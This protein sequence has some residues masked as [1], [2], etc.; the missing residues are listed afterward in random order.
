MT[1]NPILNELYDVRS[2]ILTEHGDDL[3]GYLRS[4]FQRLRAEGHPVAQIKQR[5]MRSTGAAVHA[6]SESE[7]LSP[8]PG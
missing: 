1:K 6:G 5:T 2:Q 8:P 7:S 4:E 3:R